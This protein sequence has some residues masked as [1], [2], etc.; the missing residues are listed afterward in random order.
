[1]VRVRPELVWDLRIAF[2]WPCLVR[3][4]TQAQSCRRH[5]PA[6]TQDVGT[7]ISMF[8]YWV[9]IS[10]FR[11]GTLPVPDQAKSSQQDTGIRAKL[12]WLAVEIVDRVADDMGNFSR[13]ALHR[14]QGLV[15]SAFVRKIVVAYDAAKPLFELA[16]RACSR[17]REAY[18]RISKCGRRHSPQNPNP[19]RSASSDCST[20]RTRWLHQRQPS[21]D[22]GECLHIAPL[23]GWMRSGMRCVRTQIGN[24][25]SYV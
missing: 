8:A 9:R 13:R 2:S 12:T 1:M 25:A 7:D 10:A 21:D 14:S 23:G 3:E 19:F 18:F 4:V 17:S 16:R 24:V 20:K 15:R 22:L 11:A 6:Q 5:D